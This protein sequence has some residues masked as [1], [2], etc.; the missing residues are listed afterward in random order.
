[1]RIFRGTAFLAFVVVLA[2]FGMGYASAENVFLDPSG[3]TT[4]AGG[5]VEYVLAVDS[6]PKGLSGYQIEVSLSDGS[7]GE[8]ISVSYPS[9]ASLT[10]TQGAPGDS[11]KVSAVD[12]NKQVE[13]GTGR[14]TLATIRVRADSAGSTSL[15]VNVL[16]MDA[17]GGDAISASTNGGQLTVQGSATTAPTATTTPTA[18][19]TSNPTS[20][21]SGGNPTVTVSP[22]ASASPTVS[23][24]SPSPTPVAPTGAPSLNPPGSD[25]KTYLI[26]ATLAIIA[27]AVIAGL[28]YLTKKK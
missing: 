12:L 15:N 28:Y 14:T 8:I 13:N 7:V 5:T 26:L 27:I 24:A 20:N 6:L 9:W 21:P 2:V 17:D 10:D 1:M 22:V 3:S 23:A 16:R 11:V 18:A 4:G 19:A 25:G